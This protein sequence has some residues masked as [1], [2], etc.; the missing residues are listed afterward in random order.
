MIQSRNPN[1]GTI[2]KIMEIKD[3]SFRKIPASQNESRT[4]R[5]EHNVLAFGDV[6]M[7]MRVSQMTRLSGENGPTIEVLVDSEFPPVT[8]FLVN[9]SAPPPQVQPHNLT[10]FV[11][12]CCTCETCWEGPSLFAQGSSQLRVSVLLFRSKN[13]DRAQLQ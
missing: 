5:A 7:S 6:Q 10:S 2:L 9:S 3:T 1:P 8:R 11:L 13:T 12:A 4:L